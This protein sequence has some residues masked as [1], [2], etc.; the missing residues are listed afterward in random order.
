[1]PAITS[2]KTGG[3]IL[4]IED[5]IQAALRLRSVLKKTNPEFNNI[6]VCHSIKDSIEWLNGHPHP[7]LIFMDIQLSD[8]SSFKIFSQVKISCPIIFVTAFNQYA[9]KAFEVNSID[10]I[11][12]PYSLEEVKKALDKYNTL[13]LKQ[14]TVLD[15]R[16][17]NE[18]RA[19]NPKA[20]KSRFYAKINH[21]IYSIPINQISYFHFEDN[22]TLMVTN[23][24]KSFV[25]DYSLERL[26]K[27]LNPIKFFRINRQY[28]IETNSIKKMDISNKSRIDVI[29]NDNTKEVVSRSKTKQFKDWLD[30]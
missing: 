17:L 18:L 13:N 21:S 30:L 8:G 2:H 25:I 16:V 6:P 24:K 3:T 1:M 11:L 19:L 29:L 10:Y 28:I 7:D 4:I 12:K 20:Y 26:E 5:E 9:I 23:T 27:L 22:A 14:N 15:A